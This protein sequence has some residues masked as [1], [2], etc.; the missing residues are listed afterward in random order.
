MMNLFKWSSRMGIVALILALAL[1]LATTGMAS[2]ARVQPQ[3]SSPSTS[4]ISVDPP[5][6]TVAVGQPANLTISVV[7]CTLPPQH[8][9]NISVVVT[10][11]DGTTSTYIYCLEVC[12]AFITASHTYIAVGDYHPLICLNAPTPVAQTI[13]CTYVEIDVVPAITP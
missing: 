10:W 13:A 11:G 4:C 1:V 8:L 9:P 3:D 12:R 7:S 5:T 2:A 6:Q